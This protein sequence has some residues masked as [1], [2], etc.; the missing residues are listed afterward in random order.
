MTALV[1]CI[2]AAS[3]LLL[4]HNS[5]KAADCRT[6]HDMLTHSTSDVQQLTALT[7]ANP[8]DPQVAITAYSK[9]VQTMRDYANNINEASLWG[10][11]LH[12]VELDATIVELWSQTVSH[13]PPTGIDQ[14]QISRVE[15]Q[16]VQ[17]YQR[18]NDEHDRTAAELLAK[19]PR[20]DD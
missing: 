6:V 7:L 14:G 19:C 4:Q 18:Y 2:A 16:F 13:P 8:D 9:R 20:Q 11:A 3:W 17:A 10:K 5:T 15:E 1:I 12:L